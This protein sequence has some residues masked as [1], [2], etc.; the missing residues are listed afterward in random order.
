MTKRMI[1]CLLLAGFVLLSACYG[2]ETPLPERS[3]G[4]VLPQDEQSSPQESSGESGQSGIPLPA[5]PVVRLDCFSAEGA[6]A[7]ITDAG[8]GR[9]LIKTT[10][11]YEVGET[12]WAS[13]THFY[14]IDLA[15]NTV[16]SET[17]NL[18]LDDLLG[19]GKNGE[20]VG[21][22][23]QDREVRIYDSTAVLLHAVPLTDA[24]SPFFD[25]ASQAVYCMDEEKLLRIG[26]D[27]R[28]EELAE[29][30]GVLTLQGFESETGTAFLYDG[31]LDEDVN[32]LGELTAYSVSDGRILYTVDGSA[33][34]CYDT[35]D[36]WLSSIVVRS[37]G[38]ETVETSVRLI[39]TA[40]GQSK[41][42]KAYR[43]AN[44]GFLSD[45]GQAG[46]AVWSTFAFDI[47]SSPAYSLVDL[48]AG[49][50]A[51]WTVGDG[52]EEIFTTCFTDGGK[53]LLCLTK[54]ENG[55]F[56]LYRTVPELVAYTEDLEPD[57]GFD[58]REEPDLPA[59]LAEQRALADRIEETFSVRVLVGNESVKAGNVFSYEL[60][61]T[62][63]TNRSQRKKL[64]QALYGLERVLGR[65]PEGF[66]EKFRN[67]RDAGGMRFVLVND[68]RNLYG[69]F[70]PAGVTQY[71]DGW[72]S[73]AL[74][75]DFFS[76]PLVH[77]ELWHAVECRISARDR[78]AI[79][80]DVW[81]T[82]NPEGFGYSGDYDHYSE[83]KDVMKYILP[84]AEKDAYFVSLYSA[85]LPEE[86]RATLIELVLSDDWDPSEYGEPDPLTLVR[87]SVHLIA[88]LSMLEGPVLQMFGYVYW[89]TIAA[90]YAAAP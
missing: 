28:R 27:G 1:S 8:N 12:D 7:R 65:Y 54:D 56:K 17:E 88:K 78:N 63:E 26:L 68:L 35:E 67:Y 23:Y 15:G 4:S 57:P 16:L 59:E 58:H 71:A 29:L 20:L 43:L 6:T 66:F 55:T 10:L 37:D 79:D 52:N 64:T 44:D 62:D 9:A 47:T 45:I 61:A 21:L 18:V 11:V 82:F 40:D 22:S 85:V 87:N 46:Y 50:T 38:P 42:G 60:V 73:I 80:G 33:V 19:V 41:A 86:D 34:L 3:D 76:E 83:Q 70:V 30:P 77:H 89:E 75:V 69:E 51:A 32:D 49:K 39:G 48:H 90:Q 25:P 24:F 31:N 74:D 14:L 81:K 36:V 5:E 72:Y 2:T 53:A 13:E 84:V